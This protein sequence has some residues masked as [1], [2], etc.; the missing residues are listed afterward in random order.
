M[1]EEEFNKEL[2]ADELKDLSGGFKQQ[3][4]ALRNEKKKRGNFNV[5][6]IHDTEERADAD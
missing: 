2:K 6:S 4:Y 3:Q 1:S 5:M